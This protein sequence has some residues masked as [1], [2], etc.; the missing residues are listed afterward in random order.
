M[1]I[2]RLPS[3]VCRP[4][5][6]VA[7][8]GERLLCKQEVV[9]SIPIASTTVAPLGC[10]PGGWGSRDQKP[11]QEDRFLVE[12]MRSAPLRGF[13]GDLGH[14]EEGFRSRPRRVGALGCASSRWVHA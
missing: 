8:L 7:Q 9:G 3:A 10:G 12:D 6:G 13:A 11:D 4:I 2:R 14:R 1:V 5:G